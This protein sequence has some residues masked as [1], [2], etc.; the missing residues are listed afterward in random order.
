[1]QNTIEL[2]PSDNNQSI[3]FTQQ[4]WQWSGTI[5]KMMG[6]FGG[7]APPINLPITISILNLVRQYL[8]ILIK[9][10]RGQYLKSDDQDVAFLNHLYQ[11]N[12]NDFLNLLLAFNYLDIEE[13]LEAANSFLK[14]N[15]PY[16]QNLVDGLIR[17]EA[18]KDL[19]FRLFGKEK[20]IFD[21]VESG[22]IYNI[23]Y[24]IN[25]KVDA[26]IPYWGYDV[27]LNKSS[28]DHKYPIKLGPLVA[29]PNDEIA[30][31]LIDQGANVNNEGYDNFKELTI[32]Y[33]FFCDAKSWDMV[34]I[35]LKNGANVNT[36]TDDDIRFQ[37]KT[38]E[39]EVL[40]LGQY[41]Y[42][43]A[44]G[45]PFQLSVTPTDITNMVESAKMNKGI[46]PID[47]Q[48]GGSTVHWRIKYLKYKA[49]YLKLKSR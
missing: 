36:L 21:V 37:D 41:K 42:S 12:L 14:T 1:M 3:V 46:L 23:K 26:N 31:Y 32:L 2:I 10:P 8:G 39:E 17:L 27:P 6:E 13:G 11:T 18:P 48:A 5:E 44:T 22:N 47:Y 49:K 9:N 30:Q 35:L 43:V 19:I 45:C 40:T 28:K 15:N 16:D 29:A 4:M 33:Y 34:R 7:T 20:I 24:L 38:T 25:N